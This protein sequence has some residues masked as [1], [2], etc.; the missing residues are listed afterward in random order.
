[1]ELLPLALCDARSIATEDLVPSDLVYLDKVGD[2]SIELRA[3]VFWAA[4]S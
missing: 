2:R 3:L 4:D 1:V